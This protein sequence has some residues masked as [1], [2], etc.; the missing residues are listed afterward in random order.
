MQKRATGMIRVLERFFD[1]RVGELVFSGCRH[2]AFR[3]TSLWPLQY[4]KGA[5]KQEGN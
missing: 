1:D 3:E 2:E 5:Y 4:F